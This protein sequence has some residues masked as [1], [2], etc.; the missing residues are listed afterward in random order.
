[1]MSR[2]MKNSCMSGLGVER[3]TMDLQCCIRLR[4]L[5]VVSRR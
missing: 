4:S 1:M 5:G 3:K 2:Y